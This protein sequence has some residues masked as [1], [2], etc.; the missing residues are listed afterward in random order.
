MR[1][2]VLLLSV[3]LG[4]AQ[5][6]GTPT[7]RARVN[8]INVTFTA[9]DAAGRLVQDLTQQEITLT[10]D[11]V[12]Q[13]V[14][15]FA[16]SSELPLAIGIVVDASDS[17]SKFV[18]KHAHDVAEF[19]QDVLGPNDRAFIVGFGNHIRLVS[20]FGSNVPEMLNHF[21]R[22]TKG[23]YS[24]FSEFASEESR[25]GGTALHDAVYQAAEKLKPLHDARRVLVVFSDGQDNASAHDEVEALDEAAQADVLTYAVRYTEHPP[26]RYKSRDKYGVTVMRRYAENTGGRDY[27]AQKEDMRAVFHSIA[28]ELHALYEIGYYSSDPAHDRTF[29]KVKITVTRPDVTARAKPGYFANP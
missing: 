21:E 6:A 4:I 2:A 14:R 29:R 22:Y 18:K 20:D 11:N 9:R 16:R 25:E 1:L 7:F 8:L 13:A 3:C 17:Q 24:G 12:P 15:Y 23:D 28:D 19:L 5:D 27:D 26:Q 10:E